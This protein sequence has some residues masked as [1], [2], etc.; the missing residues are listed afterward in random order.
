M[1]LL[2]QETSNQGKR[3]ARKA[4]GGSTGIEPTK[5]VPVVPDARSFSEI[6]PYLFVG[7]V[8]AS[9]N[10]GSLSGVKYSERRQR[11]RDSLTYVNRLSHATGNYTYLF[12]RWRPG[13]IPERF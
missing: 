8:V 5:V 11:T 13:V 4:E 2:N 9:R 7:S 10:K 12:L 6:T 3:E 1:M